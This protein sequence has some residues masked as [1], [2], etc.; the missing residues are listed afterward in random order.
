MGVT[1]DLGLRCRTSYLE[2]VP[3]HATSIFLKRAL[4]KNEGS[5]HMSFVTD[6]N[7]GMDK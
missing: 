1:I 6:L 3:V 7:S 5:L 4:E 2:T